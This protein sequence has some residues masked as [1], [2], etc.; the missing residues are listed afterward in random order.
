M[1]F[2]LPISRRDRPEIVNDVRRL[3]E[4]DFIAAK[5]QHVYIARIEIWFGDRRHEF[6]ELDPDVPLLCL[7]ASPCCAW[8]RKQQLKATMP[9]D[10]CTKLAAKQVGEAN[11][12]R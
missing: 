5:P 6:R 2:E 10:R 9:L 4:R 3:V 8:L 12:R 11:L 1:S 7:R